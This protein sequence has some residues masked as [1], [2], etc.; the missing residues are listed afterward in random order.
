VLSDS[1]S[2]RCCWG[3]GFASGSKDSVYSVLTRYVP[4]LLRLFL[5]EMRMRV[6]STE[7]GPLAGYLTKSRIAVIGSVLGAGAGG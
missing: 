1:G 4:Y 7:D 2:N 6:E 3:L 5:F